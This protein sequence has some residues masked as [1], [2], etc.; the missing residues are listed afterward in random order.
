VIASPR[1][2]LHKYVDPVK[3]YYYQ[4]MVQ[5]L[6]DGRLATVHRTAHGKWFP[7]CYEDKDQST[8]LIDCVTAPLATDRVAR[9]LV[10]NKFGMGLQKH[11]TV[12]QDRAQACTSQGKSHPQQLG[13]LQGQGQQHRKQALNGIRLP[14]KE[15]VACLQQREATSLPIPVVP[16]QL[17]GSTT[18]Q[19]MNDAYT[20]YT[21]V[22][23][24]L[25]S[26]KEGRHG[27]CR[28]PAE[29]MKGVCCG[30][31]SNQH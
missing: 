25:K 18:K 12:V 19:L 8:C 2:A 7:N 29:D 26:C 5:S 15:D 27:C 21:Q 10:W 17:L 31:G 16:I 30:C 28:W 24:M 3:T 22:A 6:P 14:Y 1:A 4:A 20:A 11:Q 23:G 9:E 13:P